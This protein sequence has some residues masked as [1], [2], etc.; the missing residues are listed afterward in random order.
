MFK[1]IVPILFSGFFSYSDG[2]M[3]VVMNKISCDDATCSFKVDNT[4]IYKIKLNKLSLVQK[5]EFQALKKGA[6]ISTAIP[7]GAIAN[8]DDVKK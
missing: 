4:Q 1:F 8:I 5:R 2:M 3:S 7:M 6:A